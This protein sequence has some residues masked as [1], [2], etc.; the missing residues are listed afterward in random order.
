MLK[1]RDTSRQPLRFIYN[2]LSGL[3]SPDENFGGGADRYRVRGR[4]RGTT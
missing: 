1:S 2:S 3:A 4:R